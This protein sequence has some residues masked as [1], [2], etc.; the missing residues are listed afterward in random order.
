M[1]AFYGKTAF[2]CAAA[3]MFAACSENT[4]TPT[5]RGIAPEAGS[6]NR[7]PEFNGPSAGAHILHTRQWFAQNPA[8]NGA[9]GK[10]GG[11]GGGS[12]NNGIFYHG[13]QLLT[14]ATN[15]A[16]V[17]WAGSQIYSGG[18]ALG[19]ANSG[20][21]DGSIVGY[22]L[23]HLGGSAYFNINT[24][25]YD[26]SSTPVANV[27]NYTQYWANNSYDVPANGESVSDSRMLSMLQYAFANS[28]LAYDPNTLYII[29]TAGT[30]NLGGGFGTQY[31]AYH[32]YGTVTVDGVARTVLYSA[33]PYTYAYPGACTNGTAAPNG[34]P[35]ADAE[36][37]VLAHEIEETTT[38]GHLNAWYDR[39][40]Y[41]NADKCAWK[42]GTTSTASNGGVYNITVGTKNFLVQENWVN[43][44]GGY[45]AQSYP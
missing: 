27:V 16:T 44:G 22:F 21:S 38:D 24:T 11:G 28:K 20:S 45:C 23:N 30:T 37:N 4:T 13:G 8:D 1:N 6:A 33:M 26:G 3:L 31:C 29:M 41:E 17:Y 9:H 25:Y 19:S 2:L 14:A 15:V 5:P 42:W 39:R 40:G 10:P 18:P 36:V 35:A 32:G 12:T 7:Y 43:A 34:D